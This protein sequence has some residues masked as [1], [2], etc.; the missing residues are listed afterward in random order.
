MSFHHQY[1]YPFSSVKLFFG[2][3][4]GR[5]RIFNKNK[6]YKIVLYKSRKILNIKIDYS[7]APNIF[8]NNGFRMLVSAIDLNIGW[9]QFLQVDV[10]FLLLS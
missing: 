5:N 7:S 1:G 4:T 3:I 2:E 6:V 8:P 9:K 10:K